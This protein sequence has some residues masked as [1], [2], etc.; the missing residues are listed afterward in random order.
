MM[1][2][3]RL[4]SKLHWHGITFVA[5]GQQLVKQTANMKL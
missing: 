5:A 4:F 1:Q 2:E 3:N